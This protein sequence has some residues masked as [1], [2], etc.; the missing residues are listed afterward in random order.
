MTGTY[1]YKETC[2]LNKPIDDSE[3]IGFSLP[4]YNK[5]REGIE[6][7]FNNSIPLHKVPITEFLSV[8]T[9]EYIDGFIAMSKGDLNG[10]YLNLQHMLPGFEYSLG[11]VYKTLEMMQAKELNRAYCFSMPSHHAYS[12]RGHGYCVLNTMAAGVKYAKSIGYKNVLIVDWDIHH[13]DGTQT[14]FEND[15]T[16]KQISIHNAL[17]MYMCKAS[18]LQIGSTI[19][20][21]S[22]GHINIPVVD[23]L[24]DDEFMKDPDT[25]K[26]FSGEYYR[27]E[28]SKRIFNNT[29]NSLDFQPDLIMIFDGHDSHKNDCGNDITDWVDEDFEDMTRM[30]IDLSIKHSCPILSMPGGGYNEINDIVDLAIKHVNV[31]N[32]YKA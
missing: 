14:I 25:L 28:A 8:H 30:V 22:V 21:E 1:F 32:E 17:D 9:K 6:Q 3:F 24:Y 12:D 20:G 13:G 2:K 16:V 29:I 15:P 11:G 26:E 7:K 10:E 5:V 23:S 18:S 4:H 27:A 19:Y 31:L